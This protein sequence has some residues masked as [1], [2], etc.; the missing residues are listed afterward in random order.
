[1]KFRDSPSFALLNI[2]GG[3]IVLILVLLFIFAVI[4]LGIVA[5][6]YFIVRAATNRPPPVYSSFP[7]EA[8][9]V[10]EKRDREHL[11]LLSIFH[12]MFAGLALLGI[13][14]LS[15]HYLVMHTVFSNPEMW[16][17][18]NQPPPPKAFM[19]AFIWFYLF[20]GVLLLGALVLN[21]ISGAFL[22]QRRNRIFSMVIAGLDCLQIP[23]GTALGVFTLLVLSRDSVRQLY[24]GASTTLTG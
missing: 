9:V 15:V 17:S 6:I 16:K 14:F 21:L 1:M 24:A 10:Q 20:M 18:Q 19:D 8:G 12:L 4:A 5:V 3:E 2:G 23:F 11:K 7:P 13:A 22:W